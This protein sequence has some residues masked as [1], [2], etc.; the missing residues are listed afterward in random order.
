[1][2][3]LALPAI[4]LYQKH[5][6]PYKGFA[7]AYR[8]HLGRGSCSNL[9]LRAIRRYGL[10][11]GIRILQ[12]RLALCHVAQVRHGSG[13]R[14]KQAGSAPCDLPCDLNCAP[15]CDL[16]DCGKSLRYVS[17]CDGWSC[18]GPERLRHRRRDQDKYVYL[19][20]KPGKP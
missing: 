20:P 17:C 8:V 19:P 3:A 13:L 14:G 7:C 9:G 16:P 2:R 6:S 18:D 10:L 4:R 1:M 12:Q 11:A 5:I 15:D